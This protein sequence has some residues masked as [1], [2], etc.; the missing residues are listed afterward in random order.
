M[1]IKNILYK[2]HKQRNEYIYLFIDNFLYSSLYINLDHR[3]LSLMYFLFFQGKP[4]SFLERKTNSRVINC[5]VPL[6]RLIRVLEFTYLFYRKKYLYFKSHNSFPTIT[7][8]QYGHCLIVVGQGEYKIVNFREK[9]VT[10]VFPDNFSINEIEEKISKLKEAQKC[11]L[12]PRIINWDIHRRCM[13]ECYLNLKTSSFEFNKIQKVVFP[14]LKDIILSKN[15]QKILLTEYIQNLIKSIEEIIELNTS[16][17]F[18]NNIKNILEFILFIKEEFNKHLSKEEIYLVF[19]HGDFWEGN[20]LKSK[21]KTKVIDWNTLDMRSYFFDFYFIMFDKAIKETNGFN[22]TKEINKTFNIFVCNYLK[23]YLNSNLTTG[24]INQSESYKYLFY[25]EYILLKLQENL[26]LRYLETKI[27]FFKLY[28][29]N[30][31]TNTSLLKNNQN[32]ND[33]R[34]E[35]M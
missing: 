9:I 25:L 15:H 7:T 4:F 16:S 30:K 31:N 32:V 14:I 21:T 35:N 5:F 24:L 13:E 28:E 34:V 3:L 1:L 18:R 19:S 10:T 20:I 29:N 26:E 23:N 17:D 2:K 6:V 8:S 22:I 11:R 33:S 12:A 27:N